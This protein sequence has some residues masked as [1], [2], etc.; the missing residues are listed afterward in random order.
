MI[1][2]NTDLG[3]A[4]IVETPGELP[5]V[6]TGCDLVVDVETT[7]AKP[8]E[9]VPLDNNPSKELDDGGPVQIAAD[10]AL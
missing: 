7:Y 2:S 8:F 9:E 3:K 4:H 10:C 1:T 5:T 6:P